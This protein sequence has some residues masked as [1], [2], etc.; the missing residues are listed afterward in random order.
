M[1]KSWKKLFERDYT[2]QYWETAFYMMS[3]QH[4]RV[5]PRGCAVESQV[6]YKYDDKNTGTFAPESDMQRHD[7]FLTAEYSHPEKAR[8]FLSF[9]MQLGEGYVSTAQRAAAEEDLLTAYKEYWEGWVNYTAGLWVTF[10]L[11]DLFA[12]SLRAFIERKHAEI[13]PAVPLDEVLAHA[14][15]PSTVADT[16]QAPLDASELKAHFTEAGLEA[17][18]KKYA[19]FP[20]ND[21]KFSPL[22]LEQAREI[23]DESVAVVPE[24]A[25]DVAALLHL[26][27]EEQ[28]FLERC[29][30]FF[31][32]KDLR[33]EFRRK[34]VFYVQPLYKKIAK[35]LGI[36]FEQCYSLL[37]HEIVAGLEG[38]PLPLEEANRRLHEK[39][40]LYK[41]RNKVVCLTGKAAVEKANELN[42]IVDTEDVDIK[43]F[44]GIPASTGIITGT[45]KIIK[46]A[47]HINRVEKGDI[48]VAVTT[49]PNYV[50]AMNKSN[51][52]VTDEG[53]ITSHAAIVSR[54]MKKPCVVG[55]KIATRVLHD[56]DKIEVNG[57]T[58]EIKIIE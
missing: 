34:A 22:T 4:T 38:A 2:M 48:L 8:E 57:H 7:T 30:T 28:D 50:S 21:L 46:A 55:C 11:N 9:F 14:L 58:G 1:V 41:E 15:K 43:S 49:N 53:G 27:A 25:I 24:E 12:D 37:H 56:G 20:C 36:S 3:A 44:T 45:A 29:Q 32:V 42:V 23:V 13:K 18:R 16:V 6:V 33:D 35:Q 51:A 5:V 31:Y 26:S 47:T 52:I 10:A 54:E 17:F 40:F 19:W 39:F